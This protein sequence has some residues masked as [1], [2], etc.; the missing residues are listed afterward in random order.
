[1]LQLESLM[2]MFD[3]GE[4]ELRVMGKSGCINYV[5]TAWEQVK[6][7]VQERRMSYK[8][9]R[10]ISIFGGEVTCTQ[11]KYPMP[12]DGGWVVN[13]IMTLHGVPLSDQFR[14][15][16]VNPLAMKLCKSWCA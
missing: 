2:K 3:G 1:M 6:P 15:S 11:Q 14:V 4:L 9:S 16:S 5:T 8:F 13:E 7:D 10:R 12:D